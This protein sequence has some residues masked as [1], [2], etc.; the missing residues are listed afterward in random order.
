MNV[1]K[2]RALLMAAAVCVLG[3]E[4][5]VTAFAPSAS[6]VKATGGA[7]KW[8]VTQAWHGSLKASF[9]AEDP[10]ALRHDNFSVK[11]R[12]D[13]NRGADKQHYIYQE[14][15]RPESDLA[16]PTARALS[17]L[18]QRLDDF[19]TDS[20]YS[21]LFS[22]LEEA[23][24]SSLSLAS[25]HAF[26]VSPATRIIFK[27]WV[28]STMAIGRATIISYCA[29]NAIWYTL[30]LSYTWRRIIP[31]S[32]GNTANAMCRAY[33]PLETLS[34]AIFNLHVVSQVMR[35]L[36]IVLVISLSP[37]AHQFV[38]A[39]QKRFRVSPTKVF[40]VSLASLASAVLVTWMAMLATA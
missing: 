16:P 31:V 13:A 22:T 37:L 28:Q 11:R 30:G 24:G 23:R 15:H 6:V 20:P 27:R 19:H 33:T 36:R 5:G 32:P 38:V 25:N 14:R 40:G 39:V 12:K 29:L 21:H 4:I 17:S 9:I 35:M 1:S 3:S 10:A 26:N 7:G 2:Q 8:C 18:L 34:N